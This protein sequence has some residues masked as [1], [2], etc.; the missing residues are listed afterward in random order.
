MPDPEMHFGDAELSA[1]LRSIDHRAPRISADVVMARV[2]WRHTRNS[3]LLAAAAVVVAATIATAAVPGTALNGF[4]RGL[5]GVRARPVAQSERPSSVVPAPLPV[6]AARG[7]AF[8]PGDHANV[9]FRASQASGELRLRVAD[10]ASVRVTQLTEGGDARYDLT[11][12]GV[13]V[14]NAGSTA[15][16]ELVLPTALV[17]ATVRVGGRVVAS[18]ERAVLSC[19]GKRPAAASC[20]LPLRP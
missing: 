13:D 8:V 20:V 1:M 11:P 5:L 15:S 10:V 3:A 14:D 7:I 6:A 2:R 16:Y 17:R 12:D 19:G 4:V 9:V 18:K